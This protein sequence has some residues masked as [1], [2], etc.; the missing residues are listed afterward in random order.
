MF[1][2]AL[3]ALVAV[4]AVGIG[5]YTF[6]AG[7]AK[8][9]SCC[10]LAALGLTSQDTDGCSAKSSCCAMSAA[11]CPGDAVASA[12]VPDC[13]F[14]GSDCCAGDDCCLKV[15]VFQSDAAAAATPDCCFP[16]SDCCT[17]PDCCL[18]KK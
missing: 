11:N 10:P 1:A 18:L 14:A 16:G 7:S 13:C 9:G 4:V 2:K 8:S 17:G 5:G 12:S 15:G 6:Y 3:A